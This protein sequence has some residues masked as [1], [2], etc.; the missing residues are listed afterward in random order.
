MPET[1]AKSDQTPFMPHLWEDSLF[2]LYILGNRD[3]RAH[4]DMLVPGVLFLFYDRCSLLVLRQVFSSCF[5]TGLFDLHV[6]ARK[7][8]LLFFLG[9]SSLLIGCLFLVQ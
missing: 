4:Y 1:C 2:K 6:N 3:K 9:L 7:K 5:T 8:N